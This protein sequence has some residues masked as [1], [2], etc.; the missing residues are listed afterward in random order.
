MVRTSAIINNSVVGLRA[1]NS[2]NIVRVARS[3]ITGNGIGFDSQAGGVL[4]SYGDNNVDG[5]TTD[6]TPTATIPLK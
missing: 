3:T 5:N 1:Q 4:D 6:G 2:G